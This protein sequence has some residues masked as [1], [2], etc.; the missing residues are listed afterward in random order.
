MSVETQDIKEQLEG[1]V[2]SVIRSSFH[3]TPSSDLAHGD[4]TS[5]EALQLARRRK[6][7]PSSQ[8]GI[9]PDDQEI[10]LTQPAE[11]AGHQLLNDLS[12]V[13]VSAR[14]PA[15][16]AGEIAQILSSSVLGRA[17]DVTTAAPGFVNLR[18][19]LPALTNLA[20][21]LFGLRIGQPLP[22][23]LANQTIVIEYSHPNIA[24]P[25]HFG[26]LRSTVI[27]ES[28]K[29]IFS[30]LGVTMIGI[31]HLGDWGSQFGKLLAAY[32]KWGTPQA[33][34]AGGIREMLRLYV[35]F[36]DEAERDPKLLALGAQEFAKLEQGDEENRD[37]WQQLRAASIVEF[38]AFYT[39]LGIT[40]DEPE[41]GESATV[42]ALPGLIEQALAAGIAEESEGAIVIR[43]GDDIPPV[44]I[45]KSD[46][47]TLYATRD[48]AAIAE[49]MARWQPSRIIYVVAADQA[50]HFEQLFRAA[51]RLA[52]VPGREQ[53]VYVPF[54]LVRLPEGKMSTR[55]G[56]VI[57][58][59]DVVN[60]AVS[61]AR[62]FLEEKSRDLS[63]EEKQSVAE[64]VG[65][66]A[67][68]YQDLKQQRQTT[69]VF[70]WKKMLSLQGN[71]APYLQYTVARARSVLHKALGD[72][73][74]SIDLSG[75]DGE[76][77]NLVRVVI[78][79]PWVLERAARDYAPNHL[80]DWLY[81]VASQF[82][83]VYETHPILTAPAATK[84]RRLAL[85]Q[86]VIRSLE[87]GL[88]LLG[89]GAPERL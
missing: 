21:E 51:V 42:P 13:T 32:K 80:A 18:F 30:A 61:H 7:P 23:R 9:R 54:G 89:I 44:L 78:R 2:A 34:A 10:V 6:A 62:Q 40:M 47:S 26:H 71:T 39:R 74:V 81:Q 45:R 76:E 86:L 72:D 63:P 56:R 77:I 87:Y 85:T 66:G 52:F 17:F 24:K 82:N 84:G 75:A 48:L 4:L 36:H 1:I 68:K 20:N 69:V 5:A 14:T 37:L 70:D 46:G 19:T 60:E 12:N 8:G 31:N 33:L 58:L 38:Q 53:L 64:Q 35:K 83:S 11:G 55:A 15:A 3:L 16:I 67:L 27:G 43:V 41:L 22:H 49:R 73:P 79:L 28:L 59:E 65:I 29:R 50:L 25:M 88:D 57:F